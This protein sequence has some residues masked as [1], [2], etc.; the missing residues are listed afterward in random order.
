MGSKKDRAIAV[1]NIKELRINSSK[2]SIAEIQGKRNNINDELELLKKLR[3]AQ[4]A[5]I[6]ALKKKI[7]EELKKKEEEKKKKNK[8][9]PKK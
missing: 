4:D 1:E 9:P 7:E 8:I 5:E 2:Q 3:E 6:E